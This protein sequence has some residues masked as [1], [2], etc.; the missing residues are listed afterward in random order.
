MKKIILHSITLTNFRGEKSRTTHFNDDAPTYICGDN[1]LGKSRHFDAFCWLLFGKDSHDRKDFELRTYD[2]QHQPLH[3]C[4]CSVSA[5]ISVDGIFHTIKREYQE[6]WVKPRGQ[7]EEVF[8]GNVTSCTWDDVPVKVS[9]FQKRVAHIIDETVFKMVTNPAYFAEKMKWQLQRETLMQ[10]A[11]AKSDKQIAQGNA[12]FEAL[13][14]SLNGKSLADFRKQ[15]AVEK[16]KLKAELDTIA[17]RIDQTQKLMPQA[18]KWDELKEQRKQVTQKLNDIDAQLED[19]AKIGEA[20]RKEIDNLN[21]KIQQ[22]RAKQ[23]MVE[24]AETEKQLKDIKEK[25]QLRADIET[26]LKAENTKL[27]QLNIDLGRNADRAKY[28]KSMISNVSAQLDSLRAEWRKI[29][30]SHYVGS[31]VCPVCGQPMPQH[32]IAS[33]QQDFN[34]NKAAK[35]AQNCQTGK[36]LA[37]QMK[38]YQEEYDRLQNEA[39]NINKQKAECQDAI[40]RL[41]DELHKCPKAQESIIILPNVPQWKE[42]Q[43]QIDNIQKNIAEISKP[44]QQDDVLDEL[45]RQKE[46]LH[47]QLSHI[48]L[49]LATKKQIEKAQDEITRLKQHGKE[50]AQQIADIEHREFIAQE[51]SHKK[52]EDCEQRINAMFSHVTFQL[53]DYTLDGGEIETC[54]PLVGG[55]PYAVANTAS[56]INAGLDIINTLC[57]Y[58]NVSAPIF[59]DGAESINTNSQMIFLKVTTDKQLIIK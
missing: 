18:E 42:L 2:E 15:L 28:L 44:K 14:D 45:R 50:L 36:H 59:C 26:K 29:N 6:Q 47:D 31:T 55:V 13:L 52:I 41:Y 37:Q 7:A 25:K 3:H 49:R 11:G 21:A 43:E 9:D 10:M 51:F 40:T 57:R 17:P 8:K 33:A 53:F 32:M 16:K 12:D 4:E 56:R 58:N 35:L 22:L 19:N 48:V 1:G 30:A 34:K 27:S 38:S 5:V 23:R 46:E 24:D 39:Q 20:Q 54:V